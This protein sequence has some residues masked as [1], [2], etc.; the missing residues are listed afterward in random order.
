MEERMRSMGEYA[1]EEDRGV[2]WQEERMRRRS[3]GA[4]RQFCDWLTKCL[5]LRR[6]PNSIGNFLADFV[7]H[8]AY[9]LCVHR[10]YGANGCKNAF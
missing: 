4:T 3:F 9:R 10:V 6:R 1:E 5:T 8:G 2:W 7:S